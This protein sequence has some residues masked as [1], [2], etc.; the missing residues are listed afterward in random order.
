M[1]ELPAQMVTSAPAFAGTMLIETVALLVTGEGSAMGYASAEVDTGA[2]AKWNGKIFPG[3]PESS[4]SPGLPRIEGWRMA[5]S[6]NCDPNQAIYRCEDAGRPISTPIV[7]YHGAPT[8][9]Y[10]MSFDGIGGAVSP[11][12]DLVVGVQVQ[13]HDLGG[14]GGGIISGSSTGDVIGRMVVFGFPM[15]FMKDPEATSLMRAAFGYVNASP[16]LPAMP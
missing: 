7:T 2:T 5:S 16:T 4:F 15:Y 1:V 13:A 9:I 8:G 10:M 3:E 6:F 14:S 11:R 12:E